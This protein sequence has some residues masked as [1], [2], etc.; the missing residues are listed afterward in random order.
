MLQIALCGL[1]VDDYSERHSIGPQPHPV[2]MVDIEV[3]D[4]SSV[5]SFLD[6]S[7][8]PGT[9]MPRYNGDQ[10]LCLQSPYPFARYEKQKGLL[11]H[12]VSCTL[13]IA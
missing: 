5:C 2:D 1:Q 9:G 10:S 11:V 3:C 12:L 8:V 6:L 13:S 7:I 4:S